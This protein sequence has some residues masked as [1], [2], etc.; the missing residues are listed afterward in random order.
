MERN[1][2]HH[3]M[4]I[5]RLSKSNLT[6]CVYTD[7]QTRTG[8]LL[9]RERG[10]VTDAIANDHHQG[11]FERTRWRVLLGNNLLWDWSMFR[12]VVRVYLLSVLL[13]LLGSTLSRT[14]FIISSDSNF[15]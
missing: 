2:V 10:T 6:V 11:S 4:D 14:T 8:P 15:Q 12:L 13:L 5:M 3:N 7:E 9:S 1:T